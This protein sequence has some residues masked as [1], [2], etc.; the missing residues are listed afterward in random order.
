LT[1]IELSCLRE[2]PATIYFGGGTPSL[3]PA[4]LLDQIRRSILSGAQEITV[5]AN[6]GTLS[7][8]KVRTYREIGVSRISLGAQSLEDEDLVRAGRLHK[9]KAV[10]TDFEM[11][12]H[13]GFDNINLDLIAGLPQQRFETWRSNLNRAI[14][15][16]PEH[17]SI[18]MLDH[19]ERSAWTKLPPGVPDESD[20]AQFYTEAEELLDA[21]GY[22]HYEISNWALPGRE[23]R[24]NLGYWSGVPYRGIGVG[25][26]SFDG[27]RRFWNTPSLQEYAERLDSGHLPLAGEETLTTQIQLEEAFMLGLRQA[28]GI[29]V[30]AVGD[31][32]GFEFS[33]QWR[34][35]VEQLQEAGLL[36]F[37][38]SRLQLT[39]SGRLAA[40]SV[41]AELV[42]PNGRDLMAK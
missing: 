13:A 11:L 12:R 20:Y 27:L 18:Y 26:H 35:R 23:C 30:P 32:F 24:H 10:Y 39:R 2:A 3:L 15:L 14:A 38:G 34:T 4:A 19:E 40:N 31:R 28:A 16:R 42:W 1:E 25:A 36:Q 6:P 22:H 9:A 33:Q 7:P 21:A 8:E 5:E 29:D 41:I 17:L 37:D